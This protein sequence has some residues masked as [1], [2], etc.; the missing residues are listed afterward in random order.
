MK[1]LVLILF[2]GLLSSQAADF[3]VAQTAQ[4]GDTGV[5]AAN[6][7]SLAW[8][9]NP[10]SWR[11]DASTTIYPADT[12][13]FVGTLTEAATFQDGGEHTPPNYYPVTLLFESGAKFSKAAGWAGGAIIVGTHH[14]IT[15]D[16]GVNGI[17]E[18]TDNGDGMGHQDAAVGV[19][20]T[21][22]VGLTVKN[23]TIRKLYVRTVTAGETAAPSCIQ[24]ICSVS[25][26]H[27]DN[28]VVTNCVLSDAATG[29]DADYSVA[30][31]NYTFV[32]N[33]ISNVNWGGRC[34]DER[35]GDWLVGLIM[36]SNHISGFKNWNDTT[37]N[38]YHHN[39][40]FA[41]AVSGGA[42]T[43]IIM[44]GNVIG[45]GFGGAH[46]TSG[47]FMEGAI[48]NV[49]VANNIFVSGAG[50]S[51]G[52]GLI[53]FWAHMDTGTADWRAINNTMIGTGSGIGIY[54]L[55]DNG[56]KFNVLNNV[57]NGVATAISRFSN[58][59]SVLLCDNNLGYGLT[60]GQ[61]YS[62]STAGSSDFFSFA[63]WQ[64][65]GFDQHGSSA[66]PLLDGTYHLQVGS[67]CIGLGT[68]LFSLNLPGLNADKDGN[69]RPATGAWDI[70]A[71][72]YSSAEDTNSLW[73]S[74][75]GSSNAVGTTTVTGTGTFD[76]PYAGDF[77]QILH[78][79]VDSCK[80]IRLTNGTYCT[81]PMSSGNL[82]N[83]NLIGLGTNNSK[84]LL[85]EFPGVETNSSS[86]T[87]LNFGYGGSPAILKTCRVSDLTIDCG[88]NHVD[89]QSRDA[90][91]IVGNNCVVSNVLVLRPHAKLGVSGEAFAI[92]MSLGH[93]NTVASCVV[94]SVQGD[95]MSAIGLLNQSGSVAYSNRLDTTGTA[96][97]TNVNMA[98]LNFGYVTNVSAY[99]N[100]ANC[101]QTLYM[102]TAPYYGV[103]FAYNTCT[104]F[105]RN[106]SLTGDGAGMHGF[107]VTS[108]MLCCTNVSQASIY[109][110]QYDNGH[111]EDERIIGNTFVDRGPW[112]VSQTGTN[113][114]YVRIQNNT[115]LGAG[116]NRLDGAS[117]LLD[118]S[119][120]NGPV[121][122]SGTIR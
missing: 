85:S 105:Y 35:S 83:L 102:D 76:D 46:Q 87:V 34:G 1:F 44:E 64:S 36:A 16:G 107:N 80:T 118:G 6:A 22:A 27:I 33:T 98:L 60:G 5:D 49:I 17:I 59:G 82:G 92:C 37:G 110:Y 31:S 48:H 55:A 65:I 73:V 51:W 30:C 41:W 25:P 8:F 109:Q 23:L 112:L 70:G 32:A 113:I 61:E 13:H 67:P 101:G 111:S 104:N 3:Y 4:G 24:N 26:Y 115:Y 88:S 52:D 14:D 71:Y 78:N 28:F 103:S 11:G 120:F 94:D 20:A 99:G 58:G 18:S 100:F 10:T 117:T 106:I 121:A 68:N 39:G 42:M 45:P 93:S 96:V 91:V 89:A 29:I 116:T 75:V 114:T 97:A 47:L 66:N 95:W 38:A 50:E 86:L 119:K 69:A 53:T 63:V 2:S 15:I 19:L 54:L 40:L 21:S 56:A 90:I 84:I 62:D 72:Q 43:N 9:N 77:Y 81:L 108:N 122:F 12:V 74:A 57:I 7:H 79:Q